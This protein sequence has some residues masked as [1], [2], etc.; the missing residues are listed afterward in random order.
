MRDLRIVSL[1][2]G[3]L[4]VLASAPLAA[5]NEK[6]TESETAQETSEKAD[7]TDDE[8]KESG[9]ESSAQAAGGDLEVVDAKTCSDVK[10]REPVEAGDTFG[11]GDKVTVWMAVR[12]PDSPTN[13]EAVW[14]RG[15]RE[16]HSYELKVGKSWRWRTWAHIEPDSA[17]DWSVEIQTSEGD[18][19]E[20]VDFTVE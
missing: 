6:S 9:S 12:N 2:I 11:T 10:E 15:D 3:T 14:K 16:V 5:Q 4:L 1:C 13:V 8:A 20:S 7:E 18:T 19:L 17:G